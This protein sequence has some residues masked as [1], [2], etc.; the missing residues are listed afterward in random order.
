MDT[1]HGMG[2]CCM[3][4]GW[5]CEAVKK[6]TQLKLEPLVAACSP[7]AP[8][9]P[10]AIIYDN[11]NFGETPFEQHLDNKCAFKNGMALAI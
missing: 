5:V 10:P 7:N 4:Y 9:G 1:L 11:V 2:F 8:N 3:T 6:C